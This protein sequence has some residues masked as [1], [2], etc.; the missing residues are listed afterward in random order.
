MFDSTTVTTLSFCA[1][2]PNFLDISVK[3]SE[4]GCRRL[5]LVILKVV[6][7]LAILAMVEASLATSAPS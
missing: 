4:P 1:I 3:G 2:N 7:E 6:T 5:R